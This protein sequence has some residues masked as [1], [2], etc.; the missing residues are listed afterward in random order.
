MPVK[1]F[2]LDAVRSANVDV[3]LYEEI[4]H[5]VTLVLIHKVNLKQLIYFEYHRSILYTYIYFF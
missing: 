1:R 2:A 5:N 4:P 3:F